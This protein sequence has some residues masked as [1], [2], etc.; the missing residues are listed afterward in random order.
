LRRTGVKYDGMKVRMEEGEGKVEGRE[1]GGKD[2]GR[3]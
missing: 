3:T 1:G 2:G